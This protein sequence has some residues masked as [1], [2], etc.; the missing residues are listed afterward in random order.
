M[1]VVL[2][3]L[4]S[5]WIRGKANPGR[6]GRLDTVA[7]LAVDPRLKITSLGPDRIRL[8]WPVTGINYMLMASDT[9]TSTGWTTNFPIASHTISNASHEAILNISPRRFF[10]LMGSH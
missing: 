1:A 5:L 9:L 6:E 8:Q 4:G 10:R 3:Q 2:S 7:V